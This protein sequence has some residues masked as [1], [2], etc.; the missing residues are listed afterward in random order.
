MVLPQTWLMLWGA[1]PG[2]AGHYPIRA[3]VK[4]QNASHLSC[5]KRTWFL[6]DLIVLGPDWSAAKMGV[7][8]FGQVSCLSWELATKFG[9]PL[10]DKSKVPSPLD[11]E[12]WRCPGLHT[13]LTMFFYLRL[14]ME[15]V[16]HISNDGKIINPQ[17]VCSHPLQELSCGKLGPD[18]LTWFQKGALQVLR[19]KAAC[20]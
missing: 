20:R 3:S 1:G 8:R 10:C 4:P 16:Q 2:R 12:Q 17:M 9:H 13:D 15:W 14:A 18:C 19:I 5:S 7:E 11:R 6:I